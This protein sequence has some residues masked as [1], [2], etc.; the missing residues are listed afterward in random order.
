MVLPRWIRGLRRNG[1]G[2]HRP[3]NVRRG[4][5]PH[6]RQESHLPRP[7][8]RDWAG[9]NGHRVPCAHPACRRELLRPKHGSNEPH[10]CKFLGYGPRNARV[11]RKPTRASRR[12][13]NRPEGNRVRTSVIPH[14]RTTHA[15]A[16]QHDLMGGDVV[17]KRK[18]RCVSGVPRIAARSCG[19]LL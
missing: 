5:Y 10:G 17:F 2:D 9:S 15:A 7:M 6:R 8:V 18:A 19:H 1:R 14:Q 12:T 3:R 13:E 16:H 4:L 11:Q